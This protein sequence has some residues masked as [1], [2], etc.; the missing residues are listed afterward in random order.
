MRVLAFDTECDGLELEDGTLD[1]ARARLVGCSYAERIAGKLESTYVPVGHSEGGNTFIGWALHALST[2]NCVYVCHNAGFDHRVVAAQGFEG[3]PLDSTHCTMLAAWM[4]GYPPGR[5]GL[6]ALA[7]EVLGV[8]LTDGFEDVAFG[9]PA[10]AIPVAEL[11]PY[12]RLDAEYTLRL[13]EAFKPRLEAEGLWKAFTQLEC[14]LAVGCLPHMEDTGVLV[15]RDLLESWVAPLREEGLR[16]TEQFQWLTGLSVKQSAKL[17][18]LMYGKGHWPLKRNTPRTKKNNPSINGKACELALTVC[19]PGSFGYKVAALRLAC[20]EHEKLRSTYLPRIFASLDQSPDGRM[21]GSFRQ[22]GTGT[23][24]FSSSS[25]LLTL[26]RAKTDSEGKLNDKYPLRASIIAEPGWCILGADYSQI[27]VRVLA[28]FSQDPTLLRAYQ[29]GADVHQRVADAMGVSR[30]HGKALNL[31]M[32]YGRGAAAIGNDLKLP[33]AKAK[34]LVDAYWST[35]EGVRDFRDRCHQYAAE[36]GFVRTFVGRKRLLPGM[37][38]Q[39]PEERARAGRQALNSVCQGSAVDII[40]L[41]M[42][43]LHREWLDGGVLDVSGRILFQVH[44][45]IICEVTVGTATE[46]AA[47]VKRIMESAVKL[48]G[49]PLIAEPKLGKSWLEAK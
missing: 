3:L 30:Q 20:Q 44:D 35:L 27:E 46:A 49:V 8:P 41:A 22:A 4:L 47:D 18:E 10:G 16:L 28:H 9:R 6:K 12:A 37:A 34:A 19:K 38:S 40:K 39:D 48:K 24:R 26:P 31:G 21:R 43:N 5:L 36:H 1:P 7:H 11:A 33:Y 14:P 17:G 2:D 15:D 42:R 29:E 23:G 32:M 25:P 45:E 13:Y